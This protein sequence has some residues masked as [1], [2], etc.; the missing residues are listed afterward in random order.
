MSACR[1]SPRRSSKEGRGFRQ[2]RGSLLIARV[3]LRRSQLRSGWDFGRLARLRGRTRRWAFDGGGPHGVVSFAAIAAK[4]SPGRA[5]ARCARRL[6]RRAGSAAEAEA[7]TETETQDC[8]MTALRPFPPTARGG[9]SRATC[10]RCRTRRGPVSLY[11]HEH[12]HDHDHRPGHH[13]HRLQTSRAEVHGLPAL[14]ADEVW[15][16]LRTDPG[17]E[18]RGN[19]AGAELPRPLTSAHPR[20]E[21][22]ARLAY[23]ANGALLSCPHPC[24][25]ERKNPPIWRAFTVPLPG[26]EPGFPP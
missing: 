9:G 15:R 1:P 20:N 11:G 7:G 16:P 25:Q 3:G 10:C 22:S 19:R 13:E 8:R 2:G 14:L 23:R 6:S 18:G 12:D 21:C 24:P 5:T 4:A 17:L 26:F